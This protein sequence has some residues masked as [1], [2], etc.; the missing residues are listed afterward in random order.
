MSKPNEPPPV[1]DWA[2]EHARASLRVGVSVPEIE[3]R[4]VARGL[5]PMIAEAAVT[6][7]LADRVREKTESYESLILRK[8][9][10]IAAIV[11][12]GGG[13]LLALCTGGVISAVWFLLFV[14]PILACSW[15]A[16]RIGVR[17][18]VLIRLLGLLILLLLLIY[19][20]MLFSYFFSHIR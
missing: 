19:R 6:H 15:F 20:Q 2:I 9:L 13:V 16:E 18:N 4:L 1:I 17:G 12:G 10:R 11:I 3:R 14:L 8:T 5:D 7:A